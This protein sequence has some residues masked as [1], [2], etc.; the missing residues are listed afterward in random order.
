MGSKKGFFISTI[1]FLVALVS[2]LAVG[3]YYKIK[4]RPAAEEETVDIN[5]K[6]MAF[7]NESHELLD[8]YICENTY[9]DFA[10][11]IIDD[12]NYDLKYYQAGVLETKTSVINDRY[13]FIYDS[14]NETDYEIILYDLTNQIIVN[15]YKAIKNYQTNIEANIYFVKDNNDVW[16]IL[17][18]AND[19]VLEVVAPEYTFIG[20]SDNYDIDN[21]ELIADRFIILKNNKWGIIDQSNVLLSAYLDEPII[22]YAGLYIKTK[23]GSYYKMY[24]YSGNP[25]KNGNNYIHIAITGKYLEFVTDRNKLSIYNPDTDSIVG[26]V[27]TLRKTDFSET[28]LYPPYETEI[29]GNNIEIKVYTDQEYGTY[30]L[31]KYAA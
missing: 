29:V 15:T 2:L 13:A 19:D 4:D 23:A 30:R 16:G 11:T 24:D 8:T 5:V 26:S 14:V 22:N 3:G 20:L 18:F 6:T 27:I 21:N 25:I 28:T 10:S 9:C 1:V 31:Y 17:S 12:N 7:Y